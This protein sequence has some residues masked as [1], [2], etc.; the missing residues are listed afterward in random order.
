[1]WPNGLS[2]DAENDQLYW[3]DAKRKIIESSDLD[4]QNRRVI[5]QQ[6]EHPFGL[7]VFGDFIYWSDWHEQALLRAKK[8]DGANRS[9][10]IGKLE[11]IMDIRA[12]N[13]SIRVL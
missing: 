12:V 6:I 5:L 9:V 7:T 11:G 10:V 13:V 3:S 8:E 2:V 1:M 4:G